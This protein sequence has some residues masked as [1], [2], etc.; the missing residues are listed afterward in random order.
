[1]LNILHQ[2]QHLVVV[3]KPANM[4]VHKSMIDRHETQFVMTILRDQIGQ[5]V[6]PVHR[7]DKPTSGVLM[8]ALSSDVARLLAGLFENREVKKEYHAIL[9]G[10]APEQISIDYALKEKHD[11]IADKHAKKDKEAQSALTVLE[12]VATLTVPEPV[13]RYPEARYSFVK[14]LPET[15]RKHQLRRHMAH[16][17]HPIIGDTTHGDG[18]QNKFART[19]LDF[20]QLA[21]CATKLSFTHPITGEAIACDTHFEAPMQAFVERFK[22]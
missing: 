4:L 2:D 9:R 6:Y 7:L 3:H 17:R 11:P 10:F 13:G 18:K 19:N 21:L 22:Q 5:Y 12:R 8:F 1:M 20:H 14:L 15:G 16:I